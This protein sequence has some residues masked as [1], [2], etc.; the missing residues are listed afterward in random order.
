MQAKPTIVM[1]NSMHVFP[2][3]INEERRVK[4]RAKI[5]GFSKP[6]AATT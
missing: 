6:R 1:K 3:G 5:I 2:N 4:P